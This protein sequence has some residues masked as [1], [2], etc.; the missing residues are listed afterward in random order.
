MKIQLNH[1]WKKI[2]LFKKQKQKTIAEETKINLINQCFFYFHFFEKF[3]NKI[4]ICFV[5]RKMNYIFQNS[6]KE[7]VDIDK[8]NMYLHIFANS[9]Q[10]QW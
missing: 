5:Y 4:M 2:F 6:K 1:N 10:K 8:A 9:N 7:I 3:E